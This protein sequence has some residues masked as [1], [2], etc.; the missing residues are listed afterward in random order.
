MAR[1]RENILFYSRKQK[2]KK[3][4]KP[5]ENPPNEITKRNFY[6]SFSKT[7]A[8]EHSNESVRKN[9]HKNKICSK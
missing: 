4:E 8:H 1:K 2:K 6:L 5:E 9:V 3:K 7:L